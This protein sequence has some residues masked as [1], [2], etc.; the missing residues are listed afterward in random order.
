MINRLM[1]TIY[2]GLLQTPLAVMKNL[3]I[4]WLLVSAAVAAEPV[5]FEIERTVAH[6]GFDG[7]MCWVH[8]RAGAIPTDNDSQPLVVMTMQKLLLIGSD[9]FYALNSTRTSDGG[10]TWSDP[11][12][13]LAFQRQT[14]TDKSADLPTGASI[15]P[16]LLQSGDETTVCDFAPAWHAK[17][18]RLLGIGQTVWYRNNRVVHTRPR[19][20]A[21][22]VYNPDKNQWQAWKTIKLPEEKKF[23]S[24]GSGSV[25]RVDLPNGDV[26]VPFYF[27]EPQARQY[28]VAVCRCRFD[29]ETLHYIEHGNALTIDVDRGLYEPSLTKFGKRFYLT[30]RN[31]RSGYVAASDD[32]LHFDTPKPWKF[33]DQTN[34][35]NYNT[36]Q[37][38]VAH[39]SG[40]FL[41][42]TR[43][44][45]DNDHVFR[46]RAPLFIAQVDT[47]KLH[48][49]R[50]TEKVLVP[51]RG[52]RL[53][54]FGVTIISPSETWV[55]VAEWMQPKGVEKHGSDNS[56]HVVKLQWKRTGKP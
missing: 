9:V 52:A 28:A 51:Q 44:G 8:A 20:I 4:V 32:G 56:I 37:H 22:A 23:Q 54:N 30:M 41:V 39:A 15:A 38:W 46:H 14:I 26:L 18:K 36:Q 45:A 49:I 42:Y 12:P 31:D 11:S 3:T 6:K 55:T 53:G 50:A 29:G 33:N 2:T 25:Q 1:N 34:L 13:Q 17:T 43:R 21:Y 27:K 16:E 24:A 5:E 35:G 10:K 19:G 7:K 40:L 47:D 48:V